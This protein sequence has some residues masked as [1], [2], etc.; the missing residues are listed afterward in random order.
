MPQTGVAEGWKL[1]PTMLLR[2]GV[3]EDIP[4]CALQ[5]LLFITSGSPPPPTKKLR[6]KAATFLY[7]YAE[8]AEL[9]QILVNERS[10]ELI[11]RSNIVSLW[12]SYPGDNEP[13]Y[14]KHSIQ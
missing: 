3:T 6:V 7:K 10:R 12:H 13:T 4:L 2:E 5:T 9:V 8:K 14:S 1:C 11:S